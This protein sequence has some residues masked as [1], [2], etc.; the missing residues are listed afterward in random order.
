MADLLSP[1]CPKQSWLRFS[2]RLNPEFV[3]NKSVLDFGCVKNDVQIN[4][5]LKPTHPVNNEGLL[6]NITDSH[7]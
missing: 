6:R 3:L 4:A 1:K 7:Q 2:V 5:V